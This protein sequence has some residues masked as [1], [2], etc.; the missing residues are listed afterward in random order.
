M[1][2]LV[3]GGAGFI[4]SNLV[5]AL[6]NNGNEVI[7]IDNL[8][9]G[10]ERNVN[11]NA[12]LYKLSILDEM[13]SGVF[14][15][16][17]P[18]IVFHLAAQ[19]SVTKSVTDPIFDA[20]TNILGSLNI[21]TNCVKYKVNKIVYASSSASYGTPE[22]LPV[23]EKHPINPLSA[24]GVSKHTIEHYLFMHNLLYG[25]PYTA[26]RYA[27]VYGPR[28]NPLGEGGVV[29]IFSGKLLRGEQTIIYGTGDKSRDYIYVGDVVQANLLAMDS[30][31]KGI[32][33]VGT[34]IE[35]YDKTVFD[36]IA[37]ECRYTDFPEYQPERPGEIKKMVLNNKL[38]E[39]LLKWQ[40]HVNFKEGIQKTV[41][42]YRSE[43]KLQTSAV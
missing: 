23:D 28:Q 31:E 36:L 17:Q 18:Q 15:K 10:F 22:Y 27:N 20:E 3:T 32:F 33:N 13:I 37:A 6:I 39:M 7:I 19:T 11:E 12:K 16:E 1:K 26:L 41:A 29:A 9:T 34:G 38:A 2:V 14:Q 21:I 25:L 8:S 24:Y 42:Y 30:K 35:T 4:G 40:P 43:M 5:D